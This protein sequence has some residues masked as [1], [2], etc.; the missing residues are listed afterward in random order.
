MDIFYRNVTVGPG[1]GPPRQSYKYSRVFA[2]IIGDNSQTHVALAPRRKRNG[3]TRFLT[4]HLW[5]SINANSRA[6]AR[7]RPEKSFPVFSPPSLPPPG[8][9]FGSESRRAGSALFAN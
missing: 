8:L 6:R 1:G 5:L 4:Q 9:P 2:S 3:D 7:S